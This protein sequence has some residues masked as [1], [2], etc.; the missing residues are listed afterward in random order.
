[1]TN[2]DTSVLAGRAVLVVED[3]MLVALLVE[4]LL[5]SFGCSVIGPAPSVERAL[6]AVGAAPQIDLALLDVNLGGRHVWPVAEALRVRGVPYILLTGYGGGMVPDD[7]KGA[8][9]L[10]KPFS[11][12][13][14]L[15]RLLLAFGN[16]GA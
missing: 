12:S 16:G 15:E 9:V 2:K 6:E 11:E 10:T 4:D 8:A 1:M 5:A 3:E 13:Q 7:H 14:L